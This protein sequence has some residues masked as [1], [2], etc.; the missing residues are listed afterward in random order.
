MKR[1]FVLTA[2]MCKQEDGV[3][4][5]LCHTATKV[6]SEGQAAVEGA[7]IKG[8][9]EDH[10]GYNLPKPPVVME[11]TREMMERVLAPEEPA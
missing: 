6:S 5:T 2:L 7:F 10:P 8:L 9:F 4:E 1:L 11:I 3:V